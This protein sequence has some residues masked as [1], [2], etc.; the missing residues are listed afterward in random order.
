MGSVEHRKRQRGA[1]LMRCPPTLHR[2]AT[3]LAAG[4]VDVSHCYCVGKPTQPTNRPCSTSPGE[5]PKSRRVGA[6]RS[7]SSTTLFKSVKSVKSEKRWN[8]GGLR[9]TDL[10]PTLPT[11]RRTTLGHRAVA[12]PIAP[13][14]RLKKAPA[15]HQSASPRPQSSVLPALIGRWPQL[16]RRNGR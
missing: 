1:F 12:P 15:D 7:A 3:D 2:L 10:Q 14:C 9:P 16:R 4:S 13:S 11:L 8:Y 6:K 5:M